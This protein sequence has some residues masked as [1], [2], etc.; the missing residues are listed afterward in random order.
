MTGGRT[1]QQPAASS[2]TVTVRGRNYGYA[3]TRALS[4]PASV[5]AANQVEPPGGPRT[6]HDRT[7][8]VQEG[9]QRPRTRRDPDSTGGLT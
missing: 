6:P 8:R 2:T 3:S 5:E 4:Q 1:V 7:L 9:M